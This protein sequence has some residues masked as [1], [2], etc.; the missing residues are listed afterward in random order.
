MIIKK[1]KDYPQIIQIRMDTSTI[2]EFQKKKLPTKAI[3]ER[4]AVRKATKKLQAVKSEEEWI[5]I[6]EKRNMDT[7]Y[8]RQ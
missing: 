7:R 8:S 2:Q 5:I 6:M 3:F 1:R 4:I